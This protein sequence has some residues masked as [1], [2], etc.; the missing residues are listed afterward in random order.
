MASAY[1]QEELEPLLS[2]RFILKQS[3][4]RDDGEIELIPYRPQSINVITNFIYP[5]T[6]QT[7]PIIGLD[8]L[9]LKLLDPLFNRESKNDFVRLLKAPTALHQTVTRPFDLFGGGSA[10]SINQA[11][12]ERLFND[13]VYPQHITTLLIELDDFRNFLANFIGN[14]ALRIQLQTEEGEAIWFGKRLAPQWYEIAIQEQQT[15]QLLG[16]DIILQSEFGFGLKQ[17]NWQLMLVLTLLGLGAIYYFNKLYSV[18]QRKQRNLI[19]ANAKLTHNLKT[20]SDMLE[21]ISHELNTPLTLISLANQ[22]L[23]K[24]RGE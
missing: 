2:P 7:K 18:I 1:S 20:Q 8:I 11:I 22:Q 24:R 17:I 13:K 3:R 4:I 21:H 5:L 23:Q 6:P 9:S 12:G 10:I 16:R 15:Y 19:A 14:D